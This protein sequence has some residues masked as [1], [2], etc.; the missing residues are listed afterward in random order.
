MAEYIAT[1]K[2]LRMSPK[3]IRIVVD[4]VKKMK[5]TQAVE[6]LLYV[7][8]RASEPVQKTIKTAIANARMQG[9]NVEELVFKEIQIGQG[10]TLKRGMAAPRGRYHPIMKRMSHIRVVLQTKPVE[11]K[12]LEEKKVEEPK[13]EVKKTVK[14]GKK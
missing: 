13:K 7:N 11:V 5:P 8:K 1:Q 4:A 12:K 2:F 9:A 6:V 14:K 3:K 10:P